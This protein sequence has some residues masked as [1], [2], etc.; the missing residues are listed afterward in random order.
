[1]AGYKRSKFGLKIM[2]FLNEAVLE[3]IIPCRNADESYLKEVVFPRQSTRV[4][5]IIFRANLASAG[6]LQSR[7]HPHMLWLSHLAGRL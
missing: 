7:L 4:K 5:Q 3:G 2:A 6:F 1:M